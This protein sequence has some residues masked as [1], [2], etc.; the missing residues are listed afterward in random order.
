MINNIRW[1]FS[2]CV[3]IVLFLSVP[4]PLS[5]KKK[6]PSKEKTFRYEELSPP[7]KLA[8]LANLILTGNTREAFEKLSADPNLKLDGKLKKRLQFIQA[9][10]ALNQ[11]NFEQAEGLFERLSNDYPEIDAV[12]PYWTARSQR[13]AGHPQKALETLEKSC[14]GPCLPPVA[15]TESTPEPSPGKKVKG[16][17][18]SAHKKMSTSPSLSSES[19]PRVIR[20]YA[21]AL[22]ESGN[23]DRAR[24]IFQQMISES[25]GNLPPDSA[26]LAWAECEMKAGDAQ[27]AYGEIRSLFSQASGGIPRERLEKTLQALNRK[28]PEVPGRF[29]EEDRFLRISSL[30]V[31]DRWR[32]AAEELKDLLGEISPSE[33]SLRKNETAETFFRGRLYAD[34]AREYEEILHDPGT[35]DRTAILE[36]LGS[37]YARSNQFDQ[38][39]KIQRDL[40]AASEGEASDSQ[41][42]SYK[43]AFL[44][45]DAGRYE[46]AV[47]AFQEFFDR[48]PKSPKRDDALWQ[49]AWC[50]YRLGKWGAALS[51]MDLLA[52][53][54]PRSPYAA[55]VSYWRYRILKILGPKD[56][57]QEARAAFLEKYGESFYG[58]WEERQLR[59][60]KNQCPRSGAPVVLKDERH[61]L[62]VVF[63]DVSASERASLLE[64]LALGL[65]DDFLE[66]YGKTGAAG[67]REIM[68]SP[69]KLQAWI[70]FWS[71]VE[72][73]P[74]E[75]IWAIM[76]EESH[77][78]SDALSSAGA[79]GLMQIIPQTAYQISRSLN[80]NSFKP[81]DLHNPLVNLRFGINYLSRLLR[82]FSGDI[83]YTIAAYNAGPEAVERWEAQRA[84]RPCEE[85]IEEI[86]Y[87]ETYSYVKKVMKSLWDYRDNQT[88]F[89]QA[90]D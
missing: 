80:S 1:K 43:I 89:Y 68:A 72:Q 32:E 63:A 55:R 48:F 10:L 50:L 17:Q 33:R 25:S 46:E 37:A 19:S 30:K 6:E 11:E 8:Y 5:A 41:K 81:S 88:S 78:R 26:R 73:I 38:A 76:R 27:R 7:S 86:P 13:L 54:F 70:Q 58:P 62:D 28:K 4:A 82:Q 52:D 42:T 24:E 45:A 36:K 16:R 87:R 35:E 85:F 77:F 61:A 9:Y 40:S 3:W 51:D 22:C 21:S 14:G 23:L 67:G 44:L 18:K 60:D 53:E 83:I 69:A 75:L 34:A 15:E 39:L 57:A 31:Q 65:W 47:Q 74:P 12:L 71:G 90:S 29:S 2:F 79:M 49:K 84:S 59:E 66:V 20:E 56:Q 64:L